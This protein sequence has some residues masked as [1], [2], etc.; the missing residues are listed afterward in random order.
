MRKSIVQPHSFSFFLSTLIAMKKI[1]DQEVRW[2]IVGV[3]NVCEVKS[4]PAMN[5]VPNSR[6]VAVMRRNPE[7]AEDYASRHGVP[8]WYSDAQELIDDPEINAV[9]IATPP[10]AHLPIAKLVA[11]AGKPVYVEKPMAR[12]HAEC[13][14]MVST[15]QAADVP[16]Y[17]AYYRRTLPHFLKI[18]ELIDAGAIG[19]VRTVHIDLKQVLKADLLVL[20][21]NNWRIDP[22][23]LG[24]VTFLTSLPTDWTCWTSF[25]NRFSKPKGS[26][27]TK[28]EDIRL[29][30]WSQQL[31]SLARAYWAPEPGV[32][33]HHRCLKWMRSPSMLTRDISNSRIL[34]KV[35]LR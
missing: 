8:K 32:L 18:K 5:L 30:T 25:L 11:I 14:E 15:C 10:E 23:A 19:V 12:N 7:K 31:F 1:I 17:V 21:E 4:A 33:P 6:L 28:L 27:P 3:G 13:L 29:R 20:Q 22:E 9:Y 26:P 24:A 35:N 2:G 34:E 16:L